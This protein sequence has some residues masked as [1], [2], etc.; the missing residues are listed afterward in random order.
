MMI[1]VRKNNIILFWG[2]ISFPFYD[3]LR[4]TKTVRPEWRLSPYW[5]LN[6]YFIIQVTILLVLLVVLHV[7]VY[8]YTYVNTHLCISCIKLDDTT[9]S[10][11]SDAA[12]GTL[13]VFIFLH[14]AISLVHTLKQHNNVWEEKFTIPL[15]MLCFSTYTHT[16]I[17]T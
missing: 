6:L 3:L 4:Y 5:N 15:F 1:L 12:T 9:I 13:L 10:Y 16:H 11:C 2:K 8:I 17:L 7:Y 14:E